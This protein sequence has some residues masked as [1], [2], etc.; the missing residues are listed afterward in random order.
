MIPPTNARVLVAGIGNLFCGDD[1]FGPEVVR[2]LV[3]S[4]TLPEEVRAVD[5]GIRGMHLAYDLL[6]GYDALVIVDAM[7]GMGGPGVVSVLEVGEGDLGSG[8]FDP[9]GMAP[10]AVLAS[11]ADL[12]GRL[13]PTYVVGCTPL[14]VEEGIGLSDPVQAAIP[15][16]IETVHEV[17]R[18][19]IPALAENGAG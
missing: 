2:R 10:V 7:P 6:D 13:P 5:Y 11:L 18:Q 3:A 14:D 15:A 12:G 16:A 9:H 19:R 1:G 17:I 8:E 4:G